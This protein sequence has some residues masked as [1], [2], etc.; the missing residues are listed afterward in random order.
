MR[1]LLPSSFAALATV[2]SISGVQNAMSYPFIFSPFEI[3]STSSS[4][5]T[6][7]APAFVAA[8]AFSP[9]TTRTRTHE[10]N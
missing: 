8:S 5:P 7:R 1:P 6:F 9:Y 10:K 4:P 3:C 2:L